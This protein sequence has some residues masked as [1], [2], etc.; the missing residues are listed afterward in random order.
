ME[1]LAQG[2]LLELSVALSKTWMAS[3]SPAE[4][5]DKYRKSPGVGTHACPDPAEADGPPAL[6]KVPWGVPS[7]LILVSKKGTVPPIKMCH[8]KEEYA[9]GPR[10]NFKDKVIHQML[11]FCHVSF[12][13][14]FKHFYNFM[15]MMLK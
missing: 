2:N 15:G 4:A 8:Y 5:D 12:R 7:P 3:N 9:H 6:V 13:S 1:P 10:G 14:L 11:L